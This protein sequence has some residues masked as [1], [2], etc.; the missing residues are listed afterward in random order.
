VA[1]AAAWFVALLP[2]A[3]HYSAFIYNDGLGFLAST[4]ALVAGALAL[5]RG[6]TGW[7][8]LGLAA[9]G[10]L[11]GGAALASSLW[12]YLRNRA[13]YGQLTGSQYNQALFGF[14]AQDHSARLVTSPRY[15]LD[16]FDGLWVWTRFPTRQVPVPAWGGAGLRVIVLAALAGLAVAA[17]RGFH[18][19][20]ARPAAV[21]PGDVSGRSRVAGARR[22][23]PGGVASPLM[24]VGWLVLAFLMVAW[25]DGNGGHTHARYLLPAI[26]VVAIGAAVGLDALPGAR[27][28]LT[29]LAV[30]V[31]L[32]ALTGLAWSR[33]V[34]EVAHAGMTPPSAPRAAAD[35]LHQH[36]LA[37]PWVLLAAAALTVLAG[38][39]LQQGGL[40]L[41]AT[42]AP[43]ERPALPPTDT[44]PEP[45]AHL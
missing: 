3:P 22:A 42:E 2:A 13:L 34:A 41:L 19:L 7:R 38:L 30:S 35:L 10:V 6:P 27:R 11:V 32:L 23:Q 12:F 18:R 1:V 37:H 16:L 24:L 20:G 44:R 25:Y 43:R 14:P 29:T 45:V 8:L 28:G 36:G 5:R 31:A 39:A 4:A 15:V 9:A 21:G 40:W 33:F 26:G 17:A